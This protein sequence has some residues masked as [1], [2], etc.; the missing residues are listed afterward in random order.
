MAGGSINWYVVIPDATRNLVSNPS[1]EFGTAGWAG[2][3][4]PTLGTAADDQVAGAWAAHI[5]GGAGT[6]GIRAPIS[7]AVAGGTYTASAYVR[8]R[9][10]SGGQVRISMG[11]TSTTAVLGTGDGWT[12]VSVGS[13]GAVG[14]VA[15]QR[16]SGAL[17]TLWVD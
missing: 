4:T 17:G 2:T 5:T 10:T 3:N 12:R 8:M 11:G 6:V 15:V 1:F 9:G 14:S 16:A 7:G 13:I